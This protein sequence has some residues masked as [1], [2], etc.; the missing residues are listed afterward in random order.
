M[1]RCVVPPSR[2]AVL[3]GTTPKRESHAYVGQGATAWELV[4]ELEAL[5]AQTI[6]ER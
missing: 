3:A 4:E 5:Y 2:Q 1:L 6:I